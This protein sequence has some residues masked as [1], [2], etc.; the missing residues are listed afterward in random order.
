MR[1]AARGIIN[2]TVVLEGNIK[3]K[4]GN[5]ITSYI[6]LENNIWNCLGNGSSRSLYQFIRRVLK[7]TV[8]IKEA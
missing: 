6:Y 1:C 8:V 7:Q 5:V 4:I 3:I 2:F